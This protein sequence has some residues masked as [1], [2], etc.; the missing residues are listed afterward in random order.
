MVKTKKTPAQRHAMVPAAPKG[1]SGATNAVKQ[2][3]PFA[4]RDSTS[5]DEDTAPPPKKK[6]RPPT[7]AV[8]PAAAPKG[9]GAA[10]AAPKGNDGA[11]AAGKRKLVDSS[12]EECARAPAAGRPPTNPAAKPSAKPAAPSKK[13]R[14]GTKPTKPIDSS[15]EDDPDPRAPR[16]KRVK[17]VFSTVRILGAVLGCAGNGNKGVAQHM[18]S[19]FTKEVKD[20]WKEWA[21]ET[22]P[23]HLDELPEAERKYKCPMPMKCNPPGEKPREA[24]PRRQDELITYQNTGGRGGTKKGDLQHNLDARNA[25]VEGD[26][27]VVTTIAINRGSEFKPEGKAGWDT[28]FFI[29][30]VVRVEL[31]EAPPS[32]SDGPA[33]R[34]PVTGVVAHYRMPHLRADF[35]DDI[36]KPWLLVCN[37]GHKW[38]EGCQTRR[39]CK[40]CAKVAGQESPKMTERFDPAM[41]FELDVKLKSSG[42]LTIGT[43]ERLAQW[44]PWHV[45][46]GL[47]DPSE[48]KK[49]KKPRHKLG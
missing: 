16:Q 7:P 31:G 5:K 43:K 4:P 22:P 10:A 38:D 12:D 28:P 6:K 35:H 42:A 32:S 30:D 14:D 37:G 39:P 11:K 26:I 20:D 48:A 41:V 25:F 2:R 3:R 46:L 19:F 21:R 13:K 36:K 18:P 17:P 23:D 34:R 33:V 44:G 47:P 24:A 40:S 45:E 9:K 27:A 8:V 29:A 1:K 15:D 49:P